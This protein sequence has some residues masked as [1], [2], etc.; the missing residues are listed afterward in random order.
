MR[1][2]IVFL[3]LICWTPP[4][5][6]AQG[7]TDSLIVRL[8]VTDG[9]DRLGVLAELVEL[10]YRND[11]EE[12]LRYGREALALLVAYPDA[13]L[14][15][16]LLFRKAQAHDHLAQWDSVL[17]QAERL[18]QVGAGYKKTQADAA[19][20][21]GVV[22]YRRGALGEALV[23]LE[24]AQAGYEEVGEQIGLARTLS[25]LGTVY[26]RRSDYET[27]LSLLRRAV[28]LHEELGDKHG[29]ATA[30]HRIGIIHRL[31]DNHDEALSFLS[32][33]MALREET[34][35]RRGL[36]ESFNS[37]GI[38]HKQRGD[39]DEALSFYQRSLALYEDLGDKNRV[40]SLLNNIG[41]I[42]DERGANDEALSLYTR[43]LALKEELG[44][45]R[46]IAASLATI[47][48]VYK[49]LGNYDEALAFLER[50][51][52]IREELGNQ[53]PIS[54]SLH[55]IG[56][57]HF[58][59][60]EMDKALS[61]YQRSLAIKEE[62]G[63]RSGQAVTLHSLGTVHRER[64]E[65]DEALSFYTRALSLYEEVGDPEGQ[66][67][68]LGSLGVLYGEQH[69]PAEALAATDRALVLADSI[70][71]LPLMRDAY[72]QRSALLEAD[73]R[74]AEALDAY[75]SYKAAHDAL[76]NS[77]SQGVIADLQAQYRTQEQ[78]QRIALLESNRKQQRLW[79]ALLLG[80]VGLL[81]ITVG[82]QVGRMR[83]RRRALA[84]IEKAQ[85][86]T[87]EKAA[88]LERANVLKSRFLANISHEFRTPL[89]LT[90]GPLDDLLAG[91]FQVEEAARPHLERARRN[92]GRLLRLINQL[93][94]L[95]KL[96][97]GALLLQARRHDLTAHLHQLAS[98]FASIA[99]NR[100][101]QFT[102]QVPDGPIPHVYD[103][104]KI[105]KVVI[106]LLSN[107]FKFTEPEGKILLALTREAEAAMRIEVAD[108]GP[109]IAEEHLP[110]LFD[111]FYQADSASTRT[112]EG[113]GIGLALVKEL[114]E[115]HEGTITVESTLGFGTRFTVLLPAREANVE[116][117]AEA[118]AFSAPGD[119]AAQ[120]I[121]GSL[122]IP[123]S[124]RQAG[125]EEVNAD[126]QEDV[127]TQ[128]EESED[129]A[130]AQETVV[131]IVEDNA[132]MRAYIR[133]HLEDLVTIVE[134]KN[135]REG[136]ACAVEE[137]PDLILSDV[138]MPEMDGLELCAAVKAD[139]RTSHIPV[140][141]LT[142]RAQVE[143]RIAGFESGADAYL[144]KPFNAEE[145]RVRV[146][147]LIA[148]RQRLRALFHGAT[149]PETPTEERIPDTLPAR[150]VEF[151]EK[152]YGLVEEEL[153][154]SQFGAEE[155]AEAL[156]MSRR[157][158][159]RKLCALTDEPPSTMIRR[160]R[161]ERAAALLREGE[162]SVK[163]IVFTVGYSSHSTFSR[164]FSKAYGAPPTVYAEQQATRH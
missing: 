51:L 4:I 160:L 117:E 141:L 142:A 1:W 16:H 118:A 42:H 39:Y 44:D 92:G 86:A 23:A 69:R 5:V 89:T 8:A 47:G 80:G 157:Q 57:I 140:V 109:G 127:D 6:Q 144:P 46:G 161:L 29:L 94:D 35:D 7:E 146:Q 150:E 91:R 106:N 45:R 34:G 17:V 121:T 87:E 131:L 61:F 85:Q 84:A 21:H 75:R 143:D 79:V 9:A 155:L 125:Q 81:V 137:V 153:G 18:I 99:E 76:F 59:R 22:Q 55:N 148:E 98:L 132:D 28:A 111:R 126:T 27:G 25:W 129:S 37:I 82:M 119:G 104:D 112:H 108:T 53:R 24:E 158:F 149:L 13:T 102:T 96:D 138:M 105:E 12:A 154:S 49:H 30:V 123:S 15:Q 70:G 40:A 58:E 48:N 65:M 56:N 62:L 103:S 164:V 115:L 20:L 93:L 101:I 100:Q 147:T 71:A 78:Q 3:L 11:P 122:T 120:A 151:L 90:F 114:V 152:V 19:F 97:A 133:G 77:E 67:I 54:S 95:S 38:L 31:R 107:A 52:S 163:E 68:V 113:T 41:L 26:R 83:L 50:S 88:E 14:E 32:R 73:G 36:A 128:E 60:G 74:Y 130:Q 64:G 2:C 33:A 116:E 159:H 43:S 162:M 10:T 136:V 156:H 72:R 63:N 134:A 145:L 139:E 124:L 135:G 66:A 110:H